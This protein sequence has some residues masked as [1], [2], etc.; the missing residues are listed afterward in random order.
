[1]GHTQ[2]AVAARVAPASQGSVKRGRVCAPPES[3]RHREQIFC[4]ILQVE[5]AC[6]REKNHCRRFRKSA[7][8][9]MLNKE[10]DL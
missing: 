6:S 7:L 1:M 4:L 8:L 5:A 9:C 2:A 10:K 3:W